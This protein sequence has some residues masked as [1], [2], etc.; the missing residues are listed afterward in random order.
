MIELE[1]IGVCERCGRWQY[2][3]DEYV[4][5]GSRILNTSKGEKYEELLL[6]INC[7][8]EELADRRF[9]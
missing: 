7:Q 5:K 9:E 8:E 3:D 6:C 4:V 2:E 1:A